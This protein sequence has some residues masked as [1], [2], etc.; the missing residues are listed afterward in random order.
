ML[1]ARAEELSSMQPHFRDSACRGAS[2]R[3]KEKTAA[4][5]TGP[6]R[7]GESPFAARGDAPLA[8]PAEMEKP[9]RYSV[10]FGETGQGFI[11]HVNENNTLLRVFAFEAQH[12]AAHRQRLMQ[13]G[14]P[15]PRPEVRL[16]VALDRTGKVIAVGGATES[17]ADFDG[18]GDREV[19]RELAYISDMARIFRSGGTRTLGL[20][21]RPMP[22]IRHAGTVASALR[23]FRNRQSIRFLAENESTV[24]LVRRY[25]PGAL[26]ALVDRKS[27]V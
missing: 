4:P 13:H 21:R 16:Q 23:V 6:S 2:A 12:A 9:M 17:E 10:P 19:L 11:S 14:E 24:D 27:V 15:N 7:A 25:T 22:R 18:D 1:A 5:D 20:D 8:E 26:R 3:G